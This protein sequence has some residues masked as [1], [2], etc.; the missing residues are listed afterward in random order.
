MSSH[1]EVIRL[2]AVEGTGVNP[3]DPPSRKSLWP[4]LTKIITFNAAGLPASQ[5]FLAC[6]IPI[7]PCQPAGSNLAL[8]SK[9]VVPLGDVRNSVAAAL[10][11]HAHR[12]FGAN[13]AVAPR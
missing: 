6:A 12:V 13:G 1:S 3:F 7:A 8:G 4:A 11:E 2:S 9:L 10:R 5:M